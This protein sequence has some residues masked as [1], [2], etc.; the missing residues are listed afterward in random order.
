MTSSLPNL[1]Y[2]FPG[3]GKLTAYGYWLDYDDDHK[4][5]PFPQ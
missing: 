5:G 4:S 1:G 2:T 3:F